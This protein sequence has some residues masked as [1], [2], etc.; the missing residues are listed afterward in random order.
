MFGNEQSQLVDCLALEGIDHQ[1]RERSHPRERAD[2][3]RHAVA[4]RIE[5]GS[6]RGAGDPRRTRVSHKALAL[7]C[8]RQAIGKRNLFYGR[9][10]AKSQ[11]ERSA[12]CGCVRR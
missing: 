10:R 5:Y 9:V 3:S 8:C 2:D 11:T 7:E 6:D 12:V 1:L 4:I